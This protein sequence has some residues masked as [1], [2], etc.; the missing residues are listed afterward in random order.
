[1][2][3]LQ[4]VLNYEY[5]VIKYFRVP[6]NTKINNIGTLQVFILITLLINKEK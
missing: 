1:M 3:M 2:G 5:N 6:N 4:N